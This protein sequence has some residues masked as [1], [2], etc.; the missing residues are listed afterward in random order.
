MERDIKKRK[1][2]A[3]LKISNKNRLT[4]QEYKKKKKKKKKTDPTLRQDETVT[5]FLLDADQEEINRKCVCSNGL[6]NVIGFQRGKS[7]PTSNASCVFD[8]KS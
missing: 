6:C 1:K 7:H 3:H 2:I 4:S 8:G 5:S